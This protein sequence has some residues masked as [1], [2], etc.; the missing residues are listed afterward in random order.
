MQKIILK[1]LGG[2]VKLTRLGFAIGYCIFLGACAHDSITYVGLAGTE[3]SFVKTVSPKATSCQ[4]VAVETANNT[5]TLLKMSQRKFDEATICEASLPKDTTRVIANSENINIP[6]RA[7][8]IVILGDTGC[9]LKY[10]DGKGV[11]QRCE[12][13]KEWPLATIMNSI[14]KE[15]ADVV[16]HLGDYHYREVC[17]DPVKCKAYQNDLGYG[18]KIWRLEFLNPAKN[19]LK[20]TPFVF[21]RGNHEDCQRAHEGFFKLLAPIGIDKCL[22]EHENYYTGFGNF[23]I[24]NFDN[25]NVDDKVY[26]PNSDEYLKLKERYKKLIAEIEARPETEVW[27]FVHRPIWGLSPRAA[28]RGL[29][30]DPRPENVNINMQTLVSELPLPKK[31]K[32]IFSGHVHAIQVATGNHPTQMVIGESGTSLDYFTNETLKLV[33]DGYRVFPSEYGYVVM[34]RKSDGKWTASIKGTTGS[35]DFICQVNEPNAPCLAFK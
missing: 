3:N 2:A 26:G 18:F 17:N 22:N 20:K 12:D 9:R 15:Q 27:L 14:E 1:Q 11:I 31:V 4:D 34:D 30:T 6:R 19:V 13:E 35:T 23:L 16:V 28:I 32:M 10:S 8:K 5:Q 7:Q 21:V 29:T 33:P 24:V 25:D